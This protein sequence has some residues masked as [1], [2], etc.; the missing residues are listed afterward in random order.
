MEVEPE[1]H[2]V[3]VSVSKANFGILVE[4]DLKTTRLEKIPEISMQQIEI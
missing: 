2:L 1:R 4:L 3:V